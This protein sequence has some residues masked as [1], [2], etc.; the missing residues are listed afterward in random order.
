MGWVV[1]RR[2]RSVTRL[3]LARIVLAS[4]ILRQKMRGKNGRLKRTSKKVAVHHSILIAGTLMKFRTAA[5]CQVQCQ[6][7][8]LRPPPVTTSVIGLNRFPFYYRRSNDRPLH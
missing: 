2:C 3:T 6:R 7:R 5:A 4:H 1:R 8:S